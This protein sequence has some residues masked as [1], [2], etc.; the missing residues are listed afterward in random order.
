MDAKMLL[1]IAL[2]MFSSAAVGLF[3]GYLLGRE[4]E[5]LERKEK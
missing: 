2:G 3:Y 5:K 4:I 1:I